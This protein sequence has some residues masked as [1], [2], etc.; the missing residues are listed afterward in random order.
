M[1]DTSTLLY[2]CMRTLPDGPARRR[3]KVADAGPDHPVVQGCCSES[4]LG[5]GPCGDMAAVA[6][7]LSDP[8]ATALAGG[9]IGWPFYPQTDGIITIGNEE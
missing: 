9:A 8:A 7:L 5:S 1:A 3:R 4:R 2:A 6:V